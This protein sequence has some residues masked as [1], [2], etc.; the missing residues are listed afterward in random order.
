M[1]PM[2]T[3]LASA[4]YTFNGF[5]VP[6]IVTAIACLTLGAMV[7][8]RERFTRIAW[9]FFAMTF[10]AGIWLGAFG[11]VFLANRP[12]VA[13][14]WSRLAY[15]GVPFLAPGMYGFVVRFLGVQE[16][17]RGL[18]RLAWIGATLTAVFVLSTDWMVVG[19]Q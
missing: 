2:H 19:V 1:P 13:L 14:A 15:L 16:A 12:D 5:A 4:S 7:L 9:S 10:S 11:L 6:S 8:V 17:R 3:L 18:Q